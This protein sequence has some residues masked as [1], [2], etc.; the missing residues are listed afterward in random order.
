MITNSR[1]ASRFSPLQRGWRRIFYSLLLLAAGV[2][3]IGT[4][5]ISHQLAFG[6][7]AGGKVALQL[8]KIAPWVTEHTANSQ[9]AE[10]FVVLTDQADLSQAAG[11]Q[12]KAEKGR[13]VYNALLNKSQTTQGPILSMTVSR[14]PAGMIH[15][16]PAT[17]SFT[18]LTLQ[19]QRSVTMARVT[20][21]GWR[22]ARNGSAAVTWI[23][24]PAHPLVTWNACSGFL[25]LPKSA[26]AIPTRPRHLTSL[27]TPGSA[28]LR[29]VV[30]LIRC[31]LR[32]K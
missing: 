11:L 27:L 17:I 29:K 12:S 5:A 14:I 23:R 8:G 1:F 22:P 31:K 4:F 10:F 7:V 20:R 16:F 24:A 9:Q 25:R 15:R 6:G 3:F 18:V 19:A 2:A 30:P 13:Y 21:L 32:S 26:A 28:R